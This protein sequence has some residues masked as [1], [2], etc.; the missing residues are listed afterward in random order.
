MA[1]YQLS[2]SA[3][4]DLTH[5]YEYYWKQGGLRAACKLLLRLDE[6][7]QLLAENPLLFWP[8]ENCLVVYHAERRP[9]GIVAI[10]RRGPDAEAILSSRLD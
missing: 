9:L 4:R 1:S 6:A 5:L 2:A 7:L 3:Q 8:V 10:L